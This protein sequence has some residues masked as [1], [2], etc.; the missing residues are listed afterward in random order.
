M[1]ILYPFSKKNLEPP[2]EKQLKM[3]YALEQKSG[4]KFYGKNKHDVK[5]FVE[6]A[7]QAIIDNQI[8][9]QVVKRKEER[10]K[11]LNNLD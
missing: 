3:I 10:F 5:K 11:K 6:R 4:L 8:I 9:N 2:T 1:I 7:N